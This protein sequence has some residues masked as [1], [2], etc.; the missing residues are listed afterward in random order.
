[1]LIALL[2]GVVKRNVTLEEV[3]MSCSKG[4]SLAEIV[5]EIRN[6]LDWLI[7]LPS[8]ILKEIEEFSRV[9]LRRKERIEAQIMIARYKELGKMIQN[10]YFTKGNIVSLAKDIL[11]TYP[12]NKN[13]ILYFR[14]LIGDIVLTLKEIKESLPDLGI[15]NQIIMFELVV[16]LNRLV[17]FYEKYL[18]YSDDDVVYCGEIDK[19]SEYIESVR[20]EADFFIEE[21]NRVRRVL[22]YTHG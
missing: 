14:E 12:N 7:K 17:L 18:T 4:A 8:N 2:G 6:C 15:E 21:L 3:C 19:I 16:Y 1:M 11:E 20:I 13:N 10:L 5:R 22:D 9:G